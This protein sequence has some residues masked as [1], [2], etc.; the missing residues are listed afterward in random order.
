MGIFPCFKVSI[1]IV[2]MLLF[3]LHNVITAITLADIE[4]KLFTSTL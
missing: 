2:I 3:Y 4:T 1:V